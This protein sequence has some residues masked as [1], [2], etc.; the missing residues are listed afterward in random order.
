MSL[1]RVRF[2]VR[3]M[4]V[5]TAIVGIF[6]GLVRAIESWE[7]SI[8]S[9]KYASTA[10]FHREMKQL[11]T[12]GILGEEKNAAWCKERSRKM[13]LEGNRT[14]LRAEYEAIARDCDKYASAAIEDAASW[15]RKASHY[16]AMALK[17]EKAAR[18]PW[19]PVAPDL[20]EPR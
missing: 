11:A 3:W 15:R 1:P 2:T 14:G 19:L 17:Y 16:A 13:R 18:Y 8:R 20:P 5:A 7:W 4:M 12:E 9:G 6:L 10:E